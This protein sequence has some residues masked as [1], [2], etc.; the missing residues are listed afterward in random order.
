MKLEKNKGGGKNVELHQW[1][2]MLELGTEEGEVPSFV[3][4]PAPVSE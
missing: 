3:P 2:F 4:V 1:R